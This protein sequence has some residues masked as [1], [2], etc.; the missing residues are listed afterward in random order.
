ML[1]RLLTKTTKRSR[2][3]RKFFWNGKASLL[4]GICRGGSTIITALADLG[5]AA[6]PNEEI[7][8]AIA[9][10]VCLL[11]QPRTTITIVKSYDGS[12]S[13]KSKHNQTGCHLH[14][15]ILR[16]HY[17]LM[18]WNSDRITN[19]ALPSPQQYEWQMDQDEQAHVM[20][21]L[22]SGPETITCKVWML[23]RKVFHS[24][25]Q[26]RKAQWFEQTSARAPIMG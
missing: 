11:Y 15:S 21:N 5:Q 12:F 2:Q 6:H 7:V 9:K 19:P 10:F 22:P 3:N 1:F 25:Y 4:E 13:R 26:C 14:Q 24:R 16:A 17:Q 20:T 18:V 8:A 23:Q